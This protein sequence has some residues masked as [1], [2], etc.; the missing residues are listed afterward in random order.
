MNAARW[1][2]VVLTLSL[3]GCAG[4]RLHREG[5]TLMRDGQAEEGL[6]KLTQ[7]AEVE[8][9]P[10]FRK[11]LHVQREAWIQRMLADA[12]R[13]Q[14]AGAD[15]D[16]EALYRRILPVQAN[17][18]AALD[19]L[20]RLEIVRQQAQT[21]ATARRAFAAGDQERAL[22]LLRPIT[23]E[24]PVFAPARQLLREIEAAV[25]KRHFQE[26]VLSVA[27][28]KP[29][30]LD[31]RDA[32]V[33]MVFEA[34]SRS[35]GLNFILDKDL[36][37]ELKTTVFLRN[38]QVAEAID[39]ILRT[40]QLR[41]K[42][43]G[44]NTVLIYPDTPEKLKNYQDLVVR[45]FY[46][47][48]AS[49]TQMQATLKT[50]LKTKDLVVD[51]KLNLIVMRDTPE[52]IR[53]AEKLV[54]LHDLAEPEVMLEM[55]VLEV[56]QDALLN[57]GIQW[58]TQLTLT[59]LANSSGNL[60]LA[61][62][63][64]LNSSRLGASLSSPIINLRQDS[65]LTNLLANPRIRVK[66]KEKAFVLIGDK[67]PVITTTSTS[68]GFVAESVQ[69]LD[70][71]LKLNVE[72][73]IYPSDD[74]EIKVTLEVSSIAKQI[75]TATG[76]VAYQI[77]TRNASTVLRLK[78]GQTQILAGLI[79]DQDRKSSSGVP[80]L[81]QLPVI[82]R[83]FTAPLDSSTKNEIVLSITPRLVRP[84]S[85]PDAHALEFWSGTENVLSNAPLRFAG[86]PPKD[87]K[88]TTAPASAEPPTPEVTR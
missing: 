51:E 15:G 45:A 42:L 34:L 58:P 78:D 47:Q 20:R 54:A 50:L 57:L 44:N 37:P 3:A 41:S 77:G 40:S 63:R 25:S 30:N 35:T 2:T 27:G 68:T 59:P 61:D 66:N 24:S 76:T 74:V 52:A 18:P 9:R 88:A 8:P 29:I 33:K 87:E 70:V 55:E 72:P 82:G 48:D 60:T 56:Q 5:M 31:F 14:E 36:S 7:A 28:A 23:N 62:L 86:D 12:R 85:R 4:D 67:V 71:G 49:A 64:N 39:L 22:A 73:S 75:S 79:N 43:L 32:N 46:L 21:T 53:L 11:D 13:A 81:S 10:E 16:A 26:P 38:A 6:S 80:G 17:H 69:Y 83:L 84:V 65:G 19:G 1:L